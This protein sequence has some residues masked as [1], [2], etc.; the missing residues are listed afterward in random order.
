MYKYYIFVYEP[1]VGRH[2]SVPWREKVPPLFSIKG[3]AVELLWAVVCEL[4]YGI[5]RY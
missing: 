4:F 1:A 3:R 2:G 5:Q